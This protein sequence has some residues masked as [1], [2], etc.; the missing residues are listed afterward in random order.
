MLSGLSMNKRIG[1]LLGLGL[2][3]SALYAQSAPIT[4]TV[5][6]LPGELSVHQGIASYQIPI[7][8]PEGRGGNTPQL[9]IQYSSQGAANSAL[10]VG[11]NIA[12]LS[13]IY[14]CGS[15]WFTDEQFRPVENSRLDNFCMDGNRLI[16]ADGVRGEDGSVIFYSKMILPVSH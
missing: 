10:G 8:L 9:A 6:T 12:G 11:F 3:V 1:L 5:G 2:F 15:Q 13:S 7:E 14:R 4:E 16:V